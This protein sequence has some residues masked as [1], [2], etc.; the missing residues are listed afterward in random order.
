MVFIGAAFLLSLASLISSS[1]IQNGQVRDVNFPNT[2][3]ESI[4]VND[5]GW[6]TFAP[7]ATELAYKGRWDSKFIS[8]WSSPG[9]K[10]GFTGDKVAITFGQ[11]TIAKVLV[12]YRLDTQDW[13]FTNLTT[14]GVHQF[15]SPK[16][17]GFNLS[18][19]PSRNFELRVTNWGYGVQ[20]SG[21][22]LA[23]GARL[24]KAPTYTR[25]IEIIGDSLSSGQYAS[26]EG[27][28]S[29]PWALCN[30]LGT[31][32]TVSA[33]PGNCL[34]DTECWGNLRGQSYQ[35]FQTQDTGWRS[36][37][38]YGK[39]PEPWNFTAHPA[40]D[41]VIIHLGTNDNNTHN[42]VSS[43]TYLKTYIEFARKVHDVWPKSQII[44]VSLFNSFWQDG[45][46]YRQSGI[47]VDEIK[48]VFDTLKGE[49]WIHYFDTRGI[50]AHNDIGPQWHYTDIGNVK[51]ASALMQYIRMKFGWEV[52]GAGPEIL[53]DTLYW[54]DEPGY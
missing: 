19:A 21:I 28:S 41:L 23:A 40:A 22:H 6:T 43:A 18:T 46:D 17:P 2:K 10:F 47:M 30:A 53:H 5:A 27:L 45:A 35:W 20:I 39:N 24:L 15:I 26:Y 44:L 9:L 38:L 8:Y 4:A 48:Q 42:N 34:V 31:E 50:L 11:H 25:N 49:G 3:I 51:L 12:G 1:I 52:E 14:S 33:Y 16:T 37:Q 13:Q 32:F 29:W 54:N 36:T 7:N